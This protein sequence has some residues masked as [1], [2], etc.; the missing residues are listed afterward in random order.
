MIYKD[1]Y[2]FNERHNSP[3]RHKYPS[4]YPWTWGFEPLTLS[5]VVSE[6]K[7]LINVSSTILD[8]GV[9]QPSLLPRY[10]LVKPVSR[11]SFTL[12]PSDT[13]VEA[14]STTSC[15]G[16]NENNKHNNFDNCVLVND[17]RSPWSLLPRINGQRHLPQCS[18]SSPWRHQRLQ[19][20]VNDIR[21]ATSKTTTL[22]LQIGFSDLRPTLVVR[23][24]RT[25]R[26][27]CIKF[28]L[29]VRLHQL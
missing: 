19:P 3:H 5:M 6:G 22:F 10:K 12:Q 18:S 8:F 14:T 17:G 27:N 20:L 16:S 4:G 25:R 29:V 26:R 13:I 28:L 21:I 15:N 23:H 2:Y 9:V 7:R 24:A 1:L 11:T